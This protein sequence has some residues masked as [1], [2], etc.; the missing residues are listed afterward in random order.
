M[1]IG[2]LTD[3]DRWND[4]YSL[5]H[6]VRAQVKMLERHGHEITIFLSET[7]S[8]EFPFGCNMKSE[9][10]RFSGTFFA[11]PEDI[12]HEDM[13]LAGN[14]ASRM[15]TMLTGFDVVFSHDWIFNSRKLPLAE[16]LRLSSEATRET[17]FFHWIHSVPTSGYTWW[18]LQRYGSNHQIVYP[19]STDAHLVARVFRTS[20][21]RVIP[22][23][24]VVDLRIMFGFGKT[25]TAIIDRFPG[26]M[27]ADFVQVYPAAADRLWCKGVQHLIRTFGKLKRYGSV[28][29]LIVD[30]W[31]GG[32]KAREGLE[33]YRTMALEE[34]LTEQECAFA[35][36]LLPET[37]FC[38]I[39]HREL[40]ELMLLSSV[41]VAPSI[42]ESFGLV[43]AEAC[44]AGAAIP[45]LNS[46]WSQS[47]EI[48]QGEWC[49]RRAFPSA[50]LGKENLVPDYENIAR[51]FA[52]VA[53]QDEAW[54][55]R[56][57]AR[58]AYNMDNVYN[59][60]YKPLFQRIEKA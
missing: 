13:E 2:I 58:Q 49:I 9:I 7:A 43:I 14:L 29:L 38:G 24:H 1:K 36:E 12:D 41:A 46:S 23:P 53:Q 15:V 26:L 37:E 11:E 51:S 25:S 27:R 40:M 10:P 4:S 35:S 47:W 22:V 45:V 60:H 50:E 6:V 3:L 55:A 42:G 30:S 54:T 16:A 8:Q 32:G 21:D 59:S 33:K 56:R 17:P 57:F 39:P 44:L 31:S 5:C 48:I 18:D 28:S 19:S 34:G 52:S 20:P